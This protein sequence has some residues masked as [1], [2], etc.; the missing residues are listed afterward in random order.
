MTPRIVLTGA[1]C[2]TPIGTE[3]GDFTDNLAE[4]R[5]GIGP[6]TLFDTDGFPVQIAAE[7]HDWDMSDIGE[8]PGRWAPY[9]RQTRFAVA[10]SKKAAV[11]AGIAETNVSPPRL[12]IY[13]GC[14]ETFVQLSELSDLVA[15]ATS[16]GQY[17]EDRLVAS[18]LEQPNQESP[19]SDPHL[20]A[21]GAAALCGSEGPCANI[22]AGCVSSSLAVCHAANTIQRGEADVMLA[23][24]AHSMI[25]PI[26]LSG[27]Y[28][29]EVLS[30]ANER[31]AAASRP[32]DKERD[33]FVAGEAA[34]VVVLERLEHAL[35]RGAE[36]WGELTGYAD[37]HD[38]FR[39]TD[40]HP[41]GRG[42]ATC[43]DEALRQARLNPDDIDYISAHGT[44]TPLNDRIE[45]IALKRALGEAAYKIP[46]SSIKS[47]LGHSTTGCAVV[48]LVSLLMVLR[49][50]VLPPTINYEVPDPACDLDYVPNTAREK[51][52]RH[53]MNS[54][55][56]FGGQNAVLIVSRYQGNKK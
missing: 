25:H 1:G 38:A 18:A 8:D 30:T 10:A 28:S 44:S 17:N 49:T 47:M 7:I 37:T 14:G 24:G 6:I 9:P 46:A 40:T 29:L 23:G 5:S 54:N 43:I 31:G 3:V 21:T 39:V 52:C 53:V 11:S 34:A 19:F 32:F 13:L 41:D 33:G 22:I 55:M 4:G 35:A 15:K 42:L 20:A 56:G 27:F 51:R 36:I 48:E 16:D 12:G 2:V 26:G 50:G 45:T